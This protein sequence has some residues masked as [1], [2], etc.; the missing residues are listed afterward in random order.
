MTDSTSLSFRSKTHRFR[1]IL[2]LTA[3]TILLL[4]TTSLAL[5][6]SSASIL[7][8][9]VTSMTPQ[10]ITLVD[11]SLRDSAVPMR[12]DANNFTND[13]IVFTMGSDY[14]TD[15]TEI[16]SIKPDGSEL[17]QIT[18]NGY[19]DWAPLLSPNGRRLAFCSWET[20]EAVLSIMDMYSS[21]VEPVTNQAGCS[22]YTWSADGNEIAFRADPFGTGDKVY[23]VDVDTGI[24]SDVISSEVGDKYP[25]WAPDGTKIA[26][27]GLHSNGTDRE[28]VI[29]HLDGSGREAIL[30]TSSR[31]PVWHPDSDK[32]AFEEYLGKLHVINQDGGSHSTLTTGQSAFVPS[33]SLDGTQIAYATL[34]G[35][36]LRIIN[37]DGAADHTVPNVSAGWVDGVDW[38]V[39]ASEIVIIE[40]FN[41]DT[42][43][44]QTDPDVYIADGLVHWTVERSGG[45]QFVYRDIPAFSGDVRLTV[46]GQIN[47]WNNN[48]AVAAGIGDGTD[49]GISANFG[50]TGGG[51]ATNGAFIGANG[52]TL[53]Y[54]HNSCNFTGNW[55]W[56]SAGT[57]Y[58]AELTLAN[59][60]ATLDVPGV[61]TAIG[62]PTYTGEYNT[63][64]VGLNDIGDWPSCS[65]TIDT[66]IVEQIL[67]AS[68]VNLAATSPDATQV[69]LSWDESTPDESSFHIERSID[70][71]TDWTE[72]AMVGADVTTYIDA[73][74]SCGEPY[75]YRV[76]AYRDSDEQYSSYSNVTSTNTQAC[77]DQTFRENWETGIDTGI[78][79]IYGSPQPVLVEGEGRASTWAVNP[80]GDANYDSGLIMR[81]PMNLSAGLDIDFWLKGQAPV[82]GSWTGAMIGASTCTPSD[83]NE[84]CSNYVVSINPDPELAVVKYST[85][86]ETSTEPWDALNGDWHHFHIRIRSDG[87]VEFYRNGLLKFTSTT[88]LDLGSIGDTYLDVRGRTHNSTWLI[89]DIL[90]GDESGTIIENFDSGAGFTQTDP[91]V[92]IADGKAHWTIHRDEGEQFLYRSIPAFSGDA[93]ITVV[94]QVDSW[95]NNC[96]NAIGIGDSPGAGLS[97]VYGFTGG[98]CSTNGPRI[99]VNGVTHDYSEN[100]QCTFIGNWLWITAGTPYTAELTVADGQSTLLVPGVGTS[101]GTPTY[102]GEFNTLYVG[103]NLTGDWPQCSGSFDSII[104]EPLLAGAPSDLQITGETDSSAS[105][106]WVDN[107]SDETQFHIERTQNTLGEWQ[108]IDTAGADVT[109]YEDG[110]LTCGNEYYYRVRAYHVVNGRY[111]AYSNVTSTNTQA[112]TGQTFRENW[113]TGID[114][115]TWKVYG[116]P[117]PVLVEDEGRG[118]T[119]AV[120]PNGDANYDSGLINREPMNLI[121]GLDIDFWLKGQAPVGG[122][123]TGTMIGASTC[124]PGDN[125]ETCRNYVATIHPEPEFNVV[126]YSTSTESSTEP[127]DALN[128]D[129]HQFHIRIRSD[130]LVEFYRDGLLKFTST[131]PLD[132]GSIGDTYLDVRG[133]TYNSSWLVD[134]LLVGDE[135]GT[136]IENFDSSDDFTQT[137]PDV[138]IADGQAHWTIHRDEGDQFLYRSIPAFSGD[139]R[140]TVVGQVDSWTSNCSTAIGIGDSRG[141]GLSPVYG[142]TGGGCSTNGP[143]ITVNGVTR[144]FY[145]DP[146]CT[147]IGNWLWITAGT[148]YTAELTVAD[149][150]STL[151]VPGV[152]TSYGT[153]IY[154]GEFNTLYVGAHLTGDWPQCSGSFD[155]IVIEPLLSGAPSNLTATASEAGKLTLG[156]TDNADAE[157][158][159]RIE[160]APDGTEDWQEIAI[161][162]ADTT[163]FADITVACEANYHYRVRAY[164]NWNDTYSVFSNVLNVTSSA[165]TGDENEPNDQCIDATDIDSGIPMV[166][167]IDDESDTDFY[168]IDALDP[169]ATLDIELE[170][171]EAYDFELIR[172]C[173]GGEDPISLGWARNIGTVKSISYNVGLNTGA[174][175]I[176]VF[177]PS[178]AY[179]TEDYALQ[180]TV[181]AVDPASV[182]TLI[183]IN[184]TRMQSYYD[185]ERI[186]SLSDSLEQLASHSDV[187]GLIL[188]V[189]QDAA[190]ATAYE[191]WDSDPDNTIYANNVSS[192]IKELITSLLVNFDQIEGDGYL[193]LVGDDRQIPHRRS[194]VLADDTVIPGDWMRESEYASS[195]LNTSE[196]STVGAALTNDQALSDDYYGDLSPTYR[197]DTH[198][199]YLADIPTG[200]LI[201]DPEEM[202]AVIDAY[203]EN[204]GQI[205]LTSG[206]V[207]G[208]DFVK[209][210]G[211]SQ[212]DALQAVQLN[213]DC[214]LIEDA[215]NASEMKTTLFDTPNEFVSINGHA[216]HFEHVAADSSSMSVEDIETAITNLS[217]DLVLAIGC[218][219]GL[220]V[221]PD[222]LHASDL[223]QTLA[224]KGVTNIANTGWSYGTDEAISYSEKLMQLITDEI[225]RENTAIVGK[226]LVNAKQNYWL[227]DA[228]HTPFDEQILIETT[229]YGLPMMRYQ[230]QASSASAVQDESDSE[231]VQVETTI[232]IHPE[233]RAISKIDS[234]QTVVFDSTMSQTASIEIQQMIPSLQENE[235]G[236]KGTY[237]SIQ[238][239]K[240]SDGLNPIQPTIT[241]NTSSSLGNIRGIVMWGGVYNEIQQFDPVI[242]NVSSLS[243]NA[244]LEEPDFNSSSSYPLL[245]HTLNKIEAR[246]GD[247]YDRL[248]STFGQ[249]DSSRSVERLYT[250]LTIRKYYSDS[251]NL[252]PPEIIEVSRLPVDVNLSI[253]ANVTDDVG[254][255]DVYAI[256]THGAD[257]NGE[258]QWQVL[259]LAQ[260]GDNWQGEITLV[261]P[262]WFFIQAVDEAGN[263]TTLTDDGDYF[264]YIDTIASTAQDDT[265]TFQWPHLGDH[266]ERYEIWQSSDPLFQPGDP[267]TTRI[268]SLDPPFATDPS[269]TDHFAPTEPGTHAYY[270]IRAIDTNGNI[271]AESPKAGKFNFGLEVGTSP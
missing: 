75:Y 68:P 164:R 267:G 258:G 54:Y 158:E 242:P 98:G 84:T 241:S 61:G 148:P 139:V 221:P 154:S 211:Q 187:S 118:G 81:E 15:D 193:V 25:D 137:D 156:W 210:A 52:A 58:T 49:N 244:D 189:E 179:G 186:S 19:L 255:D 206:A 152:G 45:A 181:S 231:A 240:T 40:T 271:S 135:S 80:N 51:C 74:V 268:G 178:G 173:S 115:G 171:P 43:F 142:Y 225:M 64:F 175:Y 32:L 169:F 212:C 89:D 220:T 153:P 24:I 199:V 86:S 207:S 134:D 203:L 4:G 162:G 108:E 239:G 92:Y 245:L 182:R 77:M 130:G 133:R 136:I 129:W 257:V 198:V 235:V 250:S 123:W 79:K 13:L 10:E 252:V 145:E 251:E 161:V 260:S 157:S 253:S 124:T 33:W 228:Y 266:I 125:N 35:G 21:V 30:T 170:G 230:P 93:R 234:L 37:A 95:T 261:S 216:R 167:R 219:A 222:E 18:D 183:L 73:T 143:R 7:K 132:L 20:G 197:R 119:R 1:L 41:S 14:K 85:S 111:S 140:I 190:V 99:T 248:V 69:D 26:V 109:T 163:T 88:P 120:N 151:H 29:I 55:L 141:S 214:S 128:G 104:I 114:A 155:S 227:T 264:S 72:I 224:G 66:V 205:S 97:P 82:G 17:K 12:F 83:D 3:M 131:T 233:N 201:E 176:Q 146:A 23:K 63:L 8:T 270:V 223:S 105:L 217:G 204:D 174:Y 103:A 2:L 59:G 195:Y 78:W 94:G 117:Q 192:A 71:L 202:M 180:A 76:R 218:H 60:A 110:T 70:G 67:L 87:L 28:L 96:S 16:Y 269:F 177:S 247:V 113:E 200:R 11:R 168:R 191:I 144:D 56:I 262:T 127:W 42:G 236:S 172:G 232:Y 107:T 196:L 27:E 121:A 57:P 39:D 36:N 101:N 44:I 149:G 185:F 138:Y 160:R 22:L 259:P 47:S 112:C 53:D 91:D 102:S 147:Y 254:V 6:L 184:R 243:S 209:D 213:R 238:G 31:E 65:G 5:G 229:L 106:S 48:C 62:T 38:G 215:F 150:Q 34:Y 9:R 116:S 249:F 126:R 159:F 166:A 50:F 188:E 226:A 256:Y 90:V 46:R 265:P 263:V 246:S 208:Y 100:P 237:Y 122:S 194:A 165:C